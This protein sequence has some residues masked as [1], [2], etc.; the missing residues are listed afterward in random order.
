M[1]EELKKLFERIFDLTESILRL[2]ASVIAA[3]TDGDAAG[4]GASDRMKRMTASET[5]AW[6]KTVKYFEKSD[7]KELGYILKRSDYLKNQYYKWNDISVS[8]SNEKFVADRIKELIADEKRFNAFYTL[9]SGFYRTLGVA[10]T[11]Y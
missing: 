7:L 11:R 10:A 4:A 3:A 9:L 8:G 6:A 5:I 1:G 2:T